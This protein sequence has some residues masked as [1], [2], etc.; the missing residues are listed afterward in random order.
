MPF[1]PPPIDPP[2]AAERPR[3]TTGTRFDVHLHLSQYWEGR[4]ATF[5][6]D[7]LDFSVDGLLHEL[8]GAGIG[9]GLL[10]QLYASPNVPETLREGDELERASSGRLWRSTTVDPTRGPEAV[11]DAIT[12]WERTQGLTA[13][14]L[15]PGYSPFY[16]HDPR[17]APVYEFAARRRLVVMVHQGDTLTSD[18]LV[19]FAR[20]IELDEVAV[21]FRDVRF[22]LCHLGSP[23]VEETAELV[24]KNENVYTDTSGLCGPPRLPYYARM[25]ERARRRLENLVVSVGAVDRILYGSDWPLEPIATAVDRILGL[26]LSDEEKERILGGNARRL[27]H[28]TPG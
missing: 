4:P 11:A 18:G 10:L 15:Y 5:Y 19:K 25:V 12:L 23:W 2:K 22:V 1:D 8:D 9:E 7:D 6:R 20:P 28:R 17:L 24:Y 13:I 26:P 3:A 14:K 16:P 27:F 21:R